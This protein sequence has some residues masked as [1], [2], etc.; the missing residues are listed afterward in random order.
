AQHGTADG[1]FGDANTLANARATSVA[2]M[3]RAGILSA[4]GGLVRLLRPDELPAD[5]DPAADA[6]FTI[7]E[8]AH[9]LIRVFQSSGGEEPV[10]DLL[11]K[12]LARRSDAA[13]LVRELAYQLSVAW[14]SIT[15]LAANR[16]A[17]RAPTRLL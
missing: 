15:R 4:R 2:G 9:H 10:A 8:T 6:R 13:D 1:P 11:A 7:W 3:Q 17:E 12:A 5:W 16:P 14:P